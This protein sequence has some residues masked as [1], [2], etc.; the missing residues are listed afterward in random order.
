MSARDAAVS[1]S[2]PIVLTR[3]HFVRHT[4]SCTYFF[5]FPSALP[6]SALFYLVL[7]NFFLVTLV[8]SHHYYVIVHAIT[9]KTGVRLGAFVWCT[10]HGSA[11]GLSNYSCLPKYVN[12]CAKFVENSLRGEC[13]LE[14]CEYGADHLWHVEV[15]VKVKSALFIINPVKTINFY[16]I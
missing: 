10:G 1:P 15:E 8:I 4:V 14:D 12:V 5:W 3:H 16:Y 2:W 13:T 9:R 11:V 7:C 6:S